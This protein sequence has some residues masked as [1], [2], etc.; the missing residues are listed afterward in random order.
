VEEGR[1]RTVLLGGARDDERY[2]RV[3]WHPDS[4]TV[5]FS[6]W[7]GPVCAASTPVELHEASLLVDLLVEAL[8]D[9]AGG[10][11]DDTTIMRM[12]RRSAGPSA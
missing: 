11:D 5:V 10:R 1:T 2:L 8:R 12:P 4:E 6:H 3:T 7:H 9:A